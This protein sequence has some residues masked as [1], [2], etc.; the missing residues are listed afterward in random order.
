MSDGKGKRPVD[1]EYVRG[2]AELLADADITE[3]EIRE[4]D[5]KIRVARQPQQVVMQAAAPTGPAVAPSSPPP[6]TVEVAPNAPSESEGSAPNDGSPIP[7]P[8]VGTA[9]MASSPGAEPFVR[10]GDKVTKGQ[11]IM[12]VEAM[13]TMNQIP[14]PQDGTV[15]AICVEDGQPV[16]YGETLILL[17]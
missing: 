16:E 14:S 9:Y 11:T 1:L 4:D 12:I 2:L 17:G 7:S 8:M 13:K 3:I 15:S 6:S 5:L 10:V